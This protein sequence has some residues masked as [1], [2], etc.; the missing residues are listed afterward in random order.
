M[1]GLKYLSLVNYYYLPLQLF[2]LK[3]L[4]K[5]QILEVR[6]VTMVD[7]SAEQMPAHVRRTTITLNQ[8]CSRVTA[9]GKSESKSESPACES[10]SPNAN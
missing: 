8:S 5:S 6:H 10:E 4:Y 1:L 7:R 9:T 2:H 3:Q